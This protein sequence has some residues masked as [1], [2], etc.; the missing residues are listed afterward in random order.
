MEKKNTW[1]IIIL[2]F[3]VVILG[4]YVFFDNYKDRLL[5]NEN[6][7]LNNEDTNIDGNIKNNYSIF[8]NNLKENVSNFGNKNYLF[9]SNSVIDDGYEV[10]MDNNGDLFIKYFDD[11]LSVKFGNYKISSNVLSFNVVGVGNGG[12]NNLYFINEN[13]TVGS[14]DIEFGVMNDGK[15]TVNKDLGYKN[16]VNIV[17]GTFDDGYTGVHGPLFIDINGNIFSP[18]L[19]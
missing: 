18:N 7:E 12:G 6:D 14:A 15:I 11:S 13:G 19:K 1:L 16:I 10:Y 5:I 4:G 3:L 9:V 2:S 17:S 8:A